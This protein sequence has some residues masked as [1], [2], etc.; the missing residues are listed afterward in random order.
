MSVAVSIISAVLKSVFKSNVENEL[1]NELIGISV[2]SVSEKGLSKINDFIDNGKSKVENILSVEKMKSMDI[3]ED[4]IAY[5]VAEIK[6]LLSEIEI[7][8]G[9]FRQCKYNSLKLRDFLWNEYS[10]NRAGYL[11]CESDIKKS[12]L[13]VSE[14][15]I[16]LLRESEDFIQDISVQISNAIDDTRSEMKEEFNTIKENFNKLD[17]YSQMI[18]DILW[19]MLEQNQKVKTMKDNNTKFK[20]KNISIYISYSSDDG[21]F[22]DELEKK[23]Q[24][25]G[26]KIERD[27]RDLDYTKSIK[28]FMQRIRKTDYSIIIL[29][30]RF[31]KSE[32]CMKEIFEF[33]KDE[34]YKDRIIPVRLDSVKNIWG[35]NKGIEYTV[36]WKDKEKE[37]KEQLK[38]IDEESKGG[39]IE[40]LRHISLVKDS[41]GEVIKIFRDMK[42]FDINDENIHEKISQYIKKKVI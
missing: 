34:N 22:V 38:R 13:S 30:D 4:N 14:T 31:L 39:Y 2:D 36:F 3:P 21:K 40:E 10:E 7:T 18:L 15:L 29:S 11:E 17:S 41:I 26:Y 5:I 28:E 12:L 1:V 25:Y 6:D 19:K 33:I 24:N 16:K 27:I 42:M 8:D 9:I 37:M 32:N 23:L 20:N 35:D